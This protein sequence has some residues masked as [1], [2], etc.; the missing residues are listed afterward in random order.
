M[1]LKRISVLAFLGAVVCIGWLAIHKALLGAGPVTIAI[2]VS[3]VL[4]LIWARLTFGRRSFHAAANPTSG[5]LVTRGPYR[6]LRHPIYS[7][8]LYFLW[9][10]MAAHPSPS[11]F[12]VVF[13]ASAFLGVRMFAEE[14]LLREM[15]PEYAEY[16]RHTARVLPFI[17]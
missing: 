16:A 15:Y 17:F 8:V 4:L 12:L 3:A 9:A 5:G 2:Q 11:G 6:W 10:G 7:A 13:L 14:R 1:G